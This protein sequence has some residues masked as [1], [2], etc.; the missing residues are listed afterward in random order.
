MLK[1]LDLLK[2]STVIK[3]LAADITKEKI[4]KSVEKDGEIDDPIQPIT[5]I[6][7]IALERNDSEIAGNGL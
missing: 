7:N 3:L 5:D 6:I 1:T 4:I 2:P